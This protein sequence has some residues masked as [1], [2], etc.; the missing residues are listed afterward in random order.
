M[1]DT[2]SALISTGCVYIQDSSLTLNVSSPTNGQVVPIISAG[3][4]IGNFTSVTVT[5]DRDEACDAVRVPF[6]FE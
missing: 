2:S 5:S 1:K 3:C 4:I 6:V